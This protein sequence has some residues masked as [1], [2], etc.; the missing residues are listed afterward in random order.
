M[1]FFVQSVGEILARV[2]SLGKIKK[3]KA[4]NLM[5]IT[6]EKAKEAIEQQI[7]KLTN[8]D[9]DDEF[10]TWKSSV[11]N[12]IERL[13]GK[14]SQKYHSIHVINLG[15]VTAF[16]PSSCKS[17]LYNGWK[18]SAKTIL[19][20]ILE[21]IDALGYQC[22]TNTT[23]PSASNLINVNVNQH[24]HQN[25]HQTIDFKLIIKQ[26]LQKLPSD[27]IKQVEDMITESKSKNEDRESVF[28]KVCKAATSFGCDVAA[29]SIATILMGYYW[30]L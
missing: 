14:E 28:D 27:L 21:E 15:T 25:Q 16:G 6:P 13:F 18:K 17:T 7:D 10:G 1:F 11:L 12:I 8:I 24:Q 26:A 20:G 9:S 22:P 2:Y 3:T 4:I 29:S 30:P 23:V 19:E 5:T